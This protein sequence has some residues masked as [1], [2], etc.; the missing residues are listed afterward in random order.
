MWLSHWEVK[1]FLANRE[2]GKG[3][4]V[5]SCKKEKEIPPGW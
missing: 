2:F 4:S 3:V 5:T 1:H